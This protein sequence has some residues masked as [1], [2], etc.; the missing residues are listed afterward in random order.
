MQFVLAK[1]TCGPWNMCGLPAFHK[2]S[3]A[4][5]QG[6][7]C[8][9]DPQPHKEMVQHR[10]PMQLLLDQHL[11]CHLLNLAPSQDSMAGSLG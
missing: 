2:A 1:V 5:E 6:L 4:A 3:A 10:L 7:L 9:L 11:M 8:N